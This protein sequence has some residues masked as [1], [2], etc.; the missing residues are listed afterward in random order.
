M[1]VWWFV[2]QAELQDS[3]SICELDKETLKLMSVVPSLAVSNTL[4]SADCDRW[5]ML[6]I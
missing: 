2:Q 1:F 4:L 5:L 6:L 3:T